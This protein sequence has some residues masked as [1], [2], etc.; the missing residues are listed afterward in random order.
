MALQGKDHRSRRPIATKYGHPVN[1]C[2]T[3]QPN[4][5]GSTS[6][7]QCMVSQM[8]ALTVD[9]F[10]P[11]QETCLLNVAFKSTATHPLK[12]TCPLIHDKANPAIEVH[13]GMNN[14]V[15]AKAFARSER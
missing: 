6:K 1:A 4:M 8:P 11:F 2:G 10:N 12:P 13:F 3:M 15:Q 7:L 9:K 14:V 5:L